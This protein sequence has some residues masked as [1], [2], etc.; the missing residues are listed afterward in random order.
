MSDQNGNDAIPV[1]TAEKP[2]SPLSLSERVRSLR[3]PENNGAPP[4]RRSWLPWALC[5]IL[6]GSTTY[7]GVTASTRPEPAKGKKDLEKLSNSPAEP[8]AASVGQIVT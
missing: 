8:V 2:R 7:F 5:V 6:A 1:A 4:P 3:L